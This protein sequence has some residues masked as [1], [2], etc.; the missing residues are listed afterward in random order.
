MLSVASKQTGSKPYSKACLRISPGQ[1]SPN[2]RQTRASS[3]NNCDAL[4]HCK[5]GDIR[6]IG[7]PSLD[8]PRVQNT[9]PP[10]A[11]GRSGTGSRHRCTFIEFS[12]KRSKRWPGAQQPV[13]SGTCDPAPR[14]ACLLWPFEVGLEYQGSPHGLPSRDGDLMK[15][16]R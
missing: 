13:R 8:N 3:T 7:H 10:P 9:I 12:G 16:G 1:H 11:C 14:M 6:N 2:R 4:V 5:R 15:L